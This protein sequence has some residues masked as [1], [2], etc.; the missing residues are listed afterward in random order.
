M[1]HVLPSCLRRLPCDRNGQHLKDLFPG[2]VEKQK[3]SYA[4]A[5]GKSGADGKTRHRKYHDAAMQELMKEGFEGLSDCLDKFGDLG[6]TRQNGNLFGRK[7]ACF[8]QLLAAGS[9]G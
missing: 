3:A 7:I 4:Q 2:L 6:R 5:R 8:L 9:Y 1:S